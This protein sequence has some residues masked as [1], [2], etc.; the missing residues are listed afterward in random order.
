MRSIRFYSMFGLALVGSWIGGIA[1]PLAQASMVPAEVFLAQAP[2]PG[3]L[4]ATKTVTVMVEG[5][6][7]DLLLQLYQHPEVPL[8]TY[9]PSTLTPEQFCDTD[10]CSVLFSNEATQVALIFIFPEGSTQASDMAPYV[11]GP[12][13]LITANEWVITGSYTDNLNFSWARQMVTFQTPELTATGL[14]YLG[15][16]NGRGFAVMALFPPDA[17]DGFMPEANA[18]F[19]E[20]QIQP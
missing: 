5:E 1:A 17:G 14:A 6:P 18:I 4:P 19:S 9:Y 2:D 15:E 11:T 16:A 12:E 3:S 8:V 10:G 20:V 13:G 7:Q